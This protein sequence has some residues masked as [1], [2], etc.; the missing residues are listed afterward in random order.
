MDPTITAGWIGALGGILGGA[1]GGGIAYLAAANSLDRAAAQAEAAQQAEWA[2]ARRSHQEERDE[3]RKA[4]LLALVWEL[5]VNARTAGGPGGQKGVG[6]NPIS[7]RT[8]GVERGV[9]L[10]RVVAGRG[11]GR[12]V[13]MRRW[14]SP[15]TTPRLA[16]F[17]SS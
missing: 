13:T 12:I 4:A 17:W 5:E 10:A 14:P 2:E 16:I 6:W 7:A 15:T 3:A 11:S 1:V 8:R 9:S